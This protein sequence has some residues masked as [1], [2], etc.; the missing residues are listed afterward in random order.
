MDELEED[1]DEKDI[2]EDDDLDTD[3]DDPLL[4]G[5]KKSKAKDDDLLSLDDLSE[6]EADVLP[7]DSFDDVDLW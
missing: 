2:L 3:V 5:K 4:P 6:E 7:E 1:K